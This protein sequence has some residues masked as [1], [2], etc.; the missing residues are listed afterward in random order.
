MS[1]G[2]LRRRVTLTA[3][4]VVGVV[5]V[6]AGLAVHA[7]FTAQAE[8]GLNALLAGRVQ[9]AKQLARQNVAPANLVR[10]VDAPGLRV[11]LTL[12][13][14]QRLG[15]NP[16]RG[17]ELRQARATLTGPARIS[18]ARL[19]I[20]A[21]T[22]LLSGAMRTLR[23]VLFGAGAVALLLTALGLVVGMRLALAPLDA[24][25][26]LARRIAG[27]RRGGRLRPSRPDTELGR[28][29]SAFDDMLDALEAS[30][31]RTRRFVADAAH[32]LRTPIAGVRAAAE[33][34]LA[35]GPDADPE[36][37]DRLQV[38]MV[39]ESERA[40]RLVEDLLE[41]ARLDAGLVPAHDPVD[42]AALAHAQADRVRLLAPDLTVVV[43]G[44]QHVPVTGDAD[45]LTQVIGNL[46]DNARHAMAGGGTLT[47]DV[48]RAD[49][50]ARL[51]ITDT[52]PGVPAADRERIFDRLVRLDAARRTGGAGLGLPIARGITRAHGGELRCLDHQGGARFE[53][54][55]PGGWRIAPR[56]LPLP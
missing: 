8:R 45:R 37:R 39:R 16:V 22:A 40:G 7:V 1:G 10:R 47:F 52:G 33:A 11:S 36:Q 20:T 2:S 4:G 46:A 54:D 32:E 21:D 25:T 5:L 9:L 19:V 50:R 28:A 15:E 35:L 31:E 42:L 12:P 55:L 41:L 43:R 38:L 17:G 14:G 13:S 24:M 26:G 23:Q 48:T 49:G 27:G 51:T 18:G 56:E 6:A 29:A 30:E 44:D 3:L 34:V 53:L